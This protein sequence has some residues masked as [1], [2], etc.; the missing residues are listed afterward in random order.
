ME[1][2]LGAAWGAAF[3]VA[4]GADT[5]EEAVAAEEEEE[6]EGFR[7]FA[8]NALAACALQ[9]AGQRQQCLK[10]FV[11]SKNIVM[12]TMT[13]ALHSTAAVCCRCSCQHTHSQTLPPPL[14]FPPPKPPQTRVRPT[15]AARWGRPWSGPPQSLNIALSNAE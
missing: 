2:L 6:A 1:A 11:N 7:T 5:E 10:R 13:K 8:A 15:P 14:L 9:I 12:I 3:G 4:C